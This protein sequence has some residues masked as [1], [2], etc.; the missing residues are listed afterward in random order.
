M[1]EQISEDLRLLCDYKVS[2]I[3]ALNILQSKLTQIL[4]FKNIKFESIQNIG[5]MMPLAYFAFN[6]VPSGGAKNRLLNEIDFHLLTFFNEYLKNYNSERLD[7]LE[8][9]QTLE[10]SKI[11]DKVELRRKKMECDAE[12][13]SFTKLKKEVTNATQA[14]LYKSLEIIKDANAGSVMILNSEFANYYEDAILNKDKMKKEFLD[15]MYNLYDG[16]FQGT[17]TVST[18]R[19]NITNIPVACIFMSDYKLLL[20]NEKL[21]GAF[22]SYLARGMARRSFIY[23]KKN[24]NYYTNDVEYANYDE[25][26]AAIDRLHQFA[27]KLKNTFNEIKDNKVYYFN[28]DANLEINRYKKEIDKKIKDFYKYTNI[29]TLNQ[30]ILKLNLEHSP[31]KIIK[32]AVLY[33]ILENPTSTFVTVE[34]FR[35]AVKFFNET[36]ACLEEMLNDKLISDYDTFYNYLVENRN[37]FI[38]KMDLRNQKFVPN[39]EFKGWFDDAL[40]NISEMCEEKGFNLVSRVTGKRNQ[41]FEV[42]LYEPDKYHFEAEFDGKFQKGRLIKIDNSDLEVNVL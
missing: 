24:E 33:H 36:H 1:L 31:W 15:M 26:N 38:S 8:A 10:L 39:R 18:S 23:F 21:T 28:Q 13:K 7:K 32:L 37:K 27:E 34:N 14:K 3:A 11:T 12:I 20:E 29:L 40:N 42:A 22:K 41:G 16:E 17:D 25:R 35:K 4:G 5:R 9:N 6:F 30:E 19:E 2:N